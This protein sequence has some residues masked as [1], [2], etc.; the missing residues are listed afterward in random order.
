MPSIPGIIASVGYHER[1]CLCSPP[2]QGGTGGVLP[3]GFE[4]EIRSPP[5]SH[6]L[7]EDKIS[8]F[9][10][11]MLENQREIA[12]RSVKRRLAAPAAG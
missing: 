4:I 7:A 8:D 5:G 10:R 2:L 3:P 6:Q 12:F 11:E 1:Q 9:G